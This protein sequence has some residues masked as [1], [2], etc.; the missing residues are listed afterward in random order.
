LSAAGGDY[1][2]VNESLTAAGRIDG[3]ELAGMTERHHFTLPNVSYRPDAGLAAAT[4]P[5]DARGVVILLGHG[6]PTRAQMRLAARAVKAGRRTFFYWPAEQAIEVIDAERLSSFSRHKIA[7][8]LGFRLKAWMD[9]RRARAATAAAGGAMVAAPTGPAHAGATA[10]AETAAH[11]G[12]EAESLDAHLRGGVGELR[13]ITNAY[14]DQIEAQATGADAQIAALKA[15]LKPGAEPSALAAA[16]AAAEAVQAVRAGI[17]DLRRTGG[18]VADYIEGGLPVLDRVRQQSAA[19]Q[20]GIGQVGAPAAVVTAAP[21]SGGPYGAG[22][23][24]AATAF[25]RSIAEDPRPVP[26]VLADLPTAKAPLPG[27]GVYLRLDF[28]APLTSGGSYGHT[29]YQADALARTTQDFVAVMANRFDMLDELGVRQAIVPAID[30]TGIE[31]NILGMNRHYADRLG[32][33]F[34]AMRPAYIVERAVLGNAVGAW[35]SRRFNI[36]YIVE[37]NG[38]EISMK[39]SFAGSSYD[40]EDLLLLA[41]DAAFRQATLISV[42]S[43]HV[44]ADVARRGIPESRILVN[45]NAVDLAAYSPASPD[46]REALRQSLGFESGHRVVGF[47]GTFGGWHGIDVLAASLRPILAADAS[48]RLLLIGDGNLKGLV[49]EAIARDGLSD[50]VVDVGRV[51]QAR[52]AELLKACDILV[53][54]HSSNMIDSPFFGSPTKLFEYMAMGAGIVA[55]DLEQIAH[56]LSPAIRPADLAAGSVQVID[57]RAVL[58]RPGDVDDFVRGVLGL[59]RDPAASAALGRNARLAAE[60]HYTWDQHVRNLWLRLANRPE[61]GYAVDRIRTGGGQA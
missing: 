51:P 46:E 15:A 52:G 61:E 38:S 12:L 32:L 29:C 36:P 50:R 60:R 2:V 13:R 10:L 44:A 30:P 41:E 1:L 37:Y 45:P 34:E 59:V 18:G 33:M 14:A 20:A 39:R 42:V 21:A 53:S 56:V 54:P 49:N 4:P 31:T 11:I 16:S 40:H 55:S 7:L 23:L 19:I 57:Q 25:L 6:M 22:E 17:A 24:P 43:D 3:P 48:I 47:I 8:A 27:T 35:A 9:R 5:A 26:L 58:C 28:W